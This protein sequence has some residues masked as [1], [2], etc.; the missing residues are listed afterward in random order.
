MKKFRVLITYVEAGMG[1]IV[2]AEA[3]ANALETYY[4]NE[5]EVIR[6]NFFHETNDK[7]MINH[8]KFLVDSVKRSS[9]N[10]IVL[11]GG[12]FFSRFFS[13][14][15]SYNTLLKNILHKGIDLI[16]SYHPDMVIST[17]F[18]P[19]HI[20][21]EAKKK[22][23]HIF[24]AAYIPDPN[25]HKWW[26][27]QA[28]MV[29]I[30]NSVLYDQLINEFKWK[31]E[32]IVVGK[33]ISRKEVLNAC[34]DKKVM[35]E[36]HNLPVDNFTIIMAD[37]AYAKAKLKA[38]A[39]EFLK[40]NKK[41]TLLVIAGKNDKVYDYFSN[42]K[43]KNPNV[44]LRVYHFVDDIYELYC[45]SDIFVTKTGPNAIL[46]SVQ[47]ETPIMG[48]YYASPIERITKDLY[49]NNYGVGVYCGNG[50]KARKEMESFIDNPSLLE[51][52]IENC[53]KFKKE[54]SGGE[55]LFA[56]KIVE[57]LREENKK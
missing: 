34:I 50:R 42:K 16:E 12:F 19:L 22:N 55:K 5:V 45:A 49:V 7:D 40:I 41:F 8:E 25:A 31:K 23:P 54:N 46:D 26:N 18:T 32:S 48:T 13:Q 51:T 36:K 21:V 35:R 14:E 33:F 11:Y 29:M 47:V 3:I 6:C 44:D 24:A 43:G 28:D 4:P 27:N 30:N 10:P 53:R 1:H 52:Y 39:N 56:D 17:H 57:K 38:F 15:A 20:S 37:G 9:Q 2:S